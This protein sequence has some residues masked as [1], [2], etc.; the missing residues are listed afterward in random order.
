MCSKGSWVGAMVAL[1]CFSLTC[2]AGEK[3]KKGKQ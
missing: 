1:L 2:P 3:G